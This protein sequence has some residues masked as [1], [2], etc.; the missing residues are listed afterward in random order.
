[1]SLV[2][3][4]GMVSSILYGVVVLLMLSAGPGRLRKVTATAIACSSPGVGTFFFFFF[5]CPSLPSPV[6]GL[7]GPHSSPISL[8]FPP[9]DRWA[10]KLS[11]LVRQDHIGY[12]KLSSLP[13]SASIRANFAFSRER[14]SR[15]PSAVRATSA[16]NTADAMP[17]S[18]Y[19]GA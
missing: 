3:V 19:R 1:M 12:R 6:V 17:P 5:F 7:R 2:V 16:Q 18:R 8:G 11:S 4:I 14:V 10:S 15:M 9:F 13:R